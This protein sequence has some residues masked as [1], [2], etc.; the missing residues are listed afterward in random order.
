MKPEDITEAAPYL[1]RALAKTLE[2]R[3]LSPF[4]MCE[5]FDHSFN[6]VLGSNIQIACA[7][8]IGYSEKLELRRTLE[9]AR[10]HKLKQ[11]VQDEIK[12]MKLDRIT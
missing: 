3:R 11:A 5:G 8:V 9:E 6:I 4:I 1:V 2:S 7:S 12:L 10:T